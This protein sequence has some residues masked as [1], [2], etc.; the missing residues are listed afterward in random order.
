MFSEGEFMMIIVER[1]QQGRRHG[2]R[3]IAE[4]LC[5]IHKLEVEKEDRKTDHGM[6]S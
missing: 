4:S 1:G 5:H 3:D 2:T 6:G